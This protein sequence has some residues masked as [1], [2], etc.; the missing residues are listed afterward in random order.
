MLEIAQASLEMA[1]AAYK[2]GNFA[3]RLKANYDLGVKWFV[4]RMRHFF[5]RVIDPLKT[6]SSKQK[7]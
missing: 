6:C 5:R 1:Q 2:P 4:T 7:K 3:R